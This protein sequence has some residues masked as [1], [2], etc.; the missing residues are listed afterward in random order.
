MENQTEWHLSK[1]VPLTFV[2]AI[3]IQTV[4]LV[5]YVSSM[6]NNI[7]NNEKE[8]LRQDVRINTLEGVTIT[9]LAGLSVD[10][11]SILSSPSLSVDSSVARTTTTI[12]AGQG[13]SGGG[14]LSANRTIN[15]TNTGVTATNYGSATAIPTFSVNAQGQLQQQHR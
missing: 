12:S 1:S 11:S 6:D 5:W 7:K 9:A 2:I 4:S 15:I 10:N 8:L 13:L 14:D 3:F